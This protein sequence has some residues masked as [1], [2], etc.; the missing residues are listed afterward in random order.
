MGNSSSGN[1][2]SRP[3]QGII[4][5]RQD[6]GILKSSYPSKPVVKPHPIELP[7]PIR[8]YDLFR[9]NYS[10]FRENEELKNI[11]NQR[12]FENSKHIDYKEALRKQEDSL[13]KINLEKIKSRAYQALE[14]DTPRYKSSLQSLISYKDIIKQWA[15][16][17][18][19]I[20][21]LKPKFPVL[22][23]AIEDHISR[24]SRPYPHNEL[25]IE[26]D[27]VQIL[28]KDIQTLL[29][30]N[31][32]ND[33]I[34]NAYMQLLVVRGTKPDRES[35]Y[36]FNTFFYPKLR[37]F[38]YSSVRRWTR[39]VDIFNYNII[40]VPVHLGNHWC[41]TVIDMI[42]RNI[43]YYDS[44]GGRSNN[45]CGIILNYL[46]SELSDKKKQ[47]FDHENWSTRDRYSDDIPRQ[48]NGS[49]C[50]VFACTYA[51]YITRNAKFNFSQKDMPY[52]RKKMV[53]EISMGRILE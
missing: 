14:K 39:K 51:E 5:S 19:K 16:T 10:N 36:A 49:D 38:G 24:V 53:Y 12:V 50:G 25:L 31:W 3:I 2:K 6:P 4:S 22:T 9:D 7:N 29:G 23:P 44:L 40:L 34:I 27:G 48:N 13:A 30:L 46:K 8:S 43:S 41:L 33:E 26:L 47:D 17:D 52:F 1:Q 37:D 20:F 21:G 45:C 32:L 18:D 11:F 28:R 15:I 35:V 42:R